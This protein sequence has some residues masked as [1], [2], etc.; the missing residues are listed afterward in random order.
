MAAACAS[1]VAAS[2]GQRREFL[3]ARLL[4]GDAWVDASRVPLAGRQ[5]VSFVTL[6]NLNHLLVDVP[7]GPSTG[8]E[9][10]REGWVSPSAIEAVATGLSR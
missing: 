6:A 2:V 8:V 10:Y 4:A 7:E 1:V 3:L 9:Y 5:N